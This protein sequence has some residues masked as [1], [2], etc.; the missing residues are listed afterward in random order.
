MGD[1][2]RALPWKKSDPRWKLQFVSYKS[3]DTKESKTI[4]A[5]KEWDVDPDRW[6]SLGFHKM[7]TLSEA[8]VRASTRTYQRR[9]ALEYPSTRR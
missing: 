9:R 6:H 8:R 4:K 1:Y 5:K 7:M 3:Q 2:V